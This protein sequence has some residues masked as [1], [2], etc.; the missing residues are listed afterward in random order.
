MNILWLQAAGCGGCTMSLLC[1]ESPGILD[2]LEGAGIRFL[3]HPALSLET[4]AEV[5]A[6]LERVVSGAVPLDVLCIEGAIAR[7]PR[8]TGRYQMLSATGRSMLDWVRSL[9]PL[10]RHVVAVASCAAFGG[11][12]T[13]GGNPSDAVGL[14]YD[15]AHPGGLLPPEFRS[16]SGLP[17]VNVAGCRRIPAGSARRCCCSS[18]APSTPGA[19][20]PSPGRGSTPTIWCITAARRTNITNTRPVPNACPSLAA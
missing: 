17:V 19:S 5:T 16:R 4:G 10:A 7:G 8:N 13:A 6:L 20:T 3:W 18:R 11:V 2:L 1:A 15:G 9:A 12:T 14:H